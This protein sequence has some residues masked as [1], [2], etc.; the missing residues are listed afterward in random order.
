M[1]RGAAAG[2]AF[3]CIAAI[4]AAAQS[5]P[6]EPVGYRTDDY[7]SAVPATVNGRPALSTDAAAALWRAGAAVFVD[8]LPQPPRPAGLPAGTIW[9][10]RPRYDIPNSIWL[11]DTGYGELPAIMARY[12][13]DGLRAATHGDYGRRVVF[14]CLADCWM[15]WNAARRAAALGYAQVE[16]YAEGTDGWSRH[17]LP[18][19][20][21]EPVPRPDQ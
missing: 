14:Y 17:G 13:D 18:L 11:P 1:I 9:Q 19:E 7:R 3:A 12:F 2:L 16:W 21:R 20:L 8:T 10:P 5:A 4:G 6:P 15:S